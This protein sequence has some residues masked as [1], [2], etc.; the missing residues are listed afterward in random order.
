MARA[1]STVPVVLGDKDN[2][3]L[4]KTY[5]DGHV[6]DVVEPG[7]GAGGKDRVK[8]IKCL[9]PTRTTRSAGHG[10]RKGGGNPLSPTATPTPS[11]TRSRNSRGRTLA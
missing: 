3:A 8:E 10:T 11:A 1:T 5:N 4:T 2:E 9:T 7:A 6:S